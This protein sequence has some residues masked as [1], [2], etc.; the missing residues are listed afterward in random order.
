MPNPFRGHAS[1]ALTLTRRGPLKIALY[2][3]NG[4]RVRNVHEQADANSGTHRF[5]L[6]GMNDRGERLDPGVFFYRI[7]SPDGVRQGRF[8]VLE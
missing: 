2:D 6:D 4:R 1:L 8:V 3:V 7:D 5:D